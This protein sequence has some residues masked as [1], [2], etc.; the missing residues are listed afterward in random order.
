MRTAATVGEGGTRREV[1][2][3]PNLTW[4]QPAADL[5][6]RYLHSVGRETR[7]KETGLGVRKRNK[8][9]RIFFTLP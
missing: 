2:A 1:C 6:A 5:E 3:L 8:E 4:L 9:R 7:Q